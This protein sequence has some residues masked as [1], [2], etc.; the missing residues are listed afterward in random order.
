M[1]LRAIEQFQNY[2]ICMDRKPNGMFYHCQTA[3]IL[4][5]FSIKEDLNFE[6]LNLSRKGM[7]DRLSGKDVFC[8]HSVF[9][10]MLA[11]KFA[12]CETTTAVCFAALLN[13]WVLP[14]GCSIG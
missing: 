5:D 12:S 10:P 4:P 7:T 14:V 1:R 2:N 8:A 3:C 11:G 9:V 6:D 13:A